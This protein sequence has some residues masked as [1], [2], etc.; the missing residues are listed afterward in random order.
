MAKTTDELFAEATEADYETA[1]PVTLAASDTEEEF[2]FRIDEHLRTIAIPEKGVV[3]G[4]EGDLNVNIARFTMTR[5][6]HGRDLSKLNIRINYRNA[7]GQVNYYTVSDATASGDSIIFSWEFAA[8]VTQ[9]KGNVQFVVYLFSATNAVL[10]QRFFTTLGTLE[11]L[12]GLEVDSSIPVSEQTDILLHL[13]KDLSAYAEEVKK[14]LPADYTAM[15]EQVSSLKEDIG[16]LSEEKVSKPTGDG[17]EGQVLARDADGN[18]VWRDVIT[19]LQD[20]TVTVSK[21]A[22]DVMELLNSSSGSGG[23]TLKGSLPYTVN[24]SGLYIVANSDTSVT[25]S[26]DDS[27]LIS[28]SDD[29]ITISKSTNGSN[30]DTYNKVNLSVVSE[31]CINIET[32]DASTNLCAYLNMP[33]GFLVPGEKYTIFGRIEKVVDTGKIYTSYLRFFEETIQMNLSEEISCKSFVANDNGTWGR[34]YACFQRTDGTIAGDNYNVYLYLYQGELTEMPS[35]N[36]ILSIVAGEKYSTDGYLG[37]TLTGNDADIPVYVYKTNTDNVEV[38]TDTDGVIFFGDSILDFSG[39]PALYAKKTGKP[40]ID[41]AVGGTRLSGSRDSSNEYYPYDMTN[42]ADAIASGD[43]SAQING[44]KNSQFSTLAT[45]TISNYKAIIMGFGTNDFTA[46]V[47]FHGTDITSIEGALKHILTTILTAY[48]NM[49][50]VVLSTLQYVT[51]GIGN[52]SGV[53]THD[54]G[55]VWQMNEIIKSICESDDY[56]VPWVDMYHAMGQNGL[57]RGT[58]TSDGVHLMSPNGV[59]RYNDIL[60]GQLNSLGI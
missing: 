49:R 59:K 56:C 9:Y 45:A 11:V 43:F 10:K 52:E 38:E 40:I 12:E 18:T 30:I 37:K 8:D 51:V 36:A 42:I 34:A 39:V 7:N 53:P 16:Q 23:D 13:K 28:F 41:C 21:L 27:Q 33:T 29:N 5:Y 47:P 48:P 2:Q 44:G 54:D 17:T 24:E 14:S 25:V 58:L 6:Y 19:E 57:T 20:G 31:N 50:I 1:E 55:T 22:P 32:Q 35:E 15:T 46:K 3:A 60:V 4:V 26:S